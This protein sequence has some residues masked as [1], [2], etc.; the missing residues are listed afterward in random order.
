MEEQNN[1]NVQNQKPEENNH[2]TGLNSKKAIPKMTIIIG[3]IAVAVVVIAV[4]LIVLLGGN[5][6]HHD[7]T[8]HTH[9]YGEW[10]TIKAATCTQ[11]GTESRYCSCGDNQTRPL[12]ANGHTVINIGA[13]QATC[14]TDGYTAGT[15]CSACG[16]FIVAPQKIAA[17]H[18]Y[19]SGILT[20]EA[21]CTENG[22][23]TYTCSACNA[24]YSETINS[25]H[26][27]LDATCTS[28]KTCNKCN[29]TDGE[30]LGHTCIVGTCERC[31]QEI[32][33]ELK[34]LVEL[35]ATFSRIFDSSGEILSKMTITEIS[36]EYSKN[37]DLIITFSFEKNYDKSG[38]SE[39]YD[40]GFRYKLSDDEGYIL[41]SSTYYAYNLSVGDKVKNKTITIR[42][43]NLTESEYYTLEL[44]DSG[45]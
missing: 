28:P 4:V 3:A 9:T 32:H 11:E 37:G 45:W 7:S 8:S 42:S 27:W 38:S 41:A 10:E 14:T 30:K 29:L 6:N 39:R 25:G 21:T 23:K 33:P 43:I 35:P 19:N 31:N 13:I 24:S 5:N 34:I 18:K 16:I 40:P 2:E 36:Y 22:M 15:S 26:E 44:S 1:R 12:S 17:S 20:T